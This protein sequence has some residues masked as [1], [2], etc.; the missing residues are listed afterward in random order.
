M[1]W[2]IQKTEWGIANRFNNNYIEI[3]KKLF[4]KK[5]KPLL[6]EIIKHEKQHTDEGFSL[7]DLLLDLQGFENKKL[8]WS[9]IFT[10]PKSWVQFSPIYKSMK[11]GWYFDISVFILWIII[12]LTLLLGLLSSV[13]LSQ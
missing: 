8:Y 7:R 9:F 10:T 1:S 13:Y 5:Y 11:G 2:K 3:N 12:G 4:L 6:N